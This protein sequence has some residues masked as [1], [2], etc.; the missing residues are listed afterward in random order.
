MHII[1]IACS[2]DDNYAALCGV[3]LYSLMENNKQNRLHLH[4]LSNE[5]S[6]ENL[7][8]NPIAMVFVAH[9]IP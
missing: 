4:I 3:M 7:E 8:D 2:T 1:H 6:E 9:F 5:L